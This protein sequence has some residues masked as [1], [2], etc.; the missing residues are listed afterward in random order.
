MHTPTNKKV[1]CITG[2]V[3]TGSRSAPRR[4][5]VQDG[6]LR[7]VWFTTG[8]PLSDARYRQISQTQFRIA[9][10][11]RKVLAHVGYR[12]SFMGVMQDDFDAAMAAAR[13][14]VLVVGPP[15]IAAQLAASVPGATVFSLKD[16]GMDLS[17]HLED[18]R[19][20]GQYHRIEV[21]VLAPGAW[22]E[23]HRH[24]LEILGLSPAGR[25]S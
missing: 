3:W 12:G 22:S 16:A 13:Q 5:L 1:I 20:S 10:S 18:A 11:K 7:P 8:R 15:E 25:P 19:Q 24:M 21:D 14:G 2:S 17:R 4:M 23:A 9:R 6:F